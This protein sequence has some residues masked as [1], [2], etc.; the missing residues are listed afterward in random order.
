MSTQLK[1]QFNIISINW[2]GIEKEKVQIKILDIIHKLG[3]ECVDIFTF[4]FPEFVTREVIN[5][6][7]HNTCFVCGGLMADGQALENTWVGFDDFGGDAGEPGTT[8]SKI[9]PPVMLKVR[10]CTVCGYSHT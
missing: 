3:G 1:P 10:K 6:V 5:Q 9:G 8:I 2:S 7:I 4:K